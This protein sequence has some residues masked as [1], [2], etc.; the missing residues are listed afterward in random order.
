MEDIIKY[1]NEKYRP[2]TIIVYGSYCDGTNNLNSDFDALIIYN[3]KKQIH[4]TNFFNDIQL[5]VFVY[6]YSYFLEEYDIEQFL[7]IFDGK[8]VFDTNDIG[9][10][11][12]DDVL[13][14]I[15]KNKVKS[16]EEI[17]TNISWCVKMLERTKRHDSE[18]MFRWHWLLV[19]SLEIFCDVIKHPYFG[20]KKTLKWMQ[21]HYPDIFIIYKKALENLEYSYL[22]EW[23]NCLKKI[24]QE[25]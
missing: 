2:L 19:D 7:Q 4:D 21:K 14:Y 24:S 8:I 10:K 20:P 16:A 3:D 13:K 17:Q 9:K 22:Y 23:I 5:D 25:Q 18:G 12:K 1:L 6:P 15:R 11:L